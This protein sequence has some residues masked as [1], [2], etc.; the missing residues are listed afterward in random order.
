[1]T[2]WHCLSVKPEELRLDTT[3]NC[4]QSF[5]W[6]NTGDNQ[7]TSVLSG[8]I[9]TLRQTDDDIL[10]R[11]PG[12]NVGDVAELLRDYFQ[13]DVDLGELYKQWRTDANFE[14]KAG[15]FMGIR[16]LR[17]DPVE[18]LFTFICTS[19]NN[20]QRITT[21]VSKLCQH[22]GTEIGTVDEIS[23]PFY[24]FPT[25]AR[26]AQ[27]NVENE[28]RQ[29]GFGY[30][31]KYISQTA[32]YIM[33]HHDET[34]LRGLRN[35]PYEE[36][37]D[38]L[39]KLAGVGPKVADCVCLMSMDKPGAIP[40]D[41]HVW[42]IAKRDYKLSGL[43]SKTLTQKNYLAIGDRFRTIFGT[44]AGWAHSVLFTADLRQFEHRL[45]SSVEN[46]SNIVLEGKREEAPQPR[47][48]KKTA[49]VTVLDRYPR[50]KRRIL[51]GDHEKK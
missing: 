33:E 51:E 43:A 7:W 22:Y 49:G 8:R 23:K 2:T 34:W 5:R 21:M 11:T 42:Q 18:N 39:L 14:K 30:R 37:R 1:M 45:V 35:L 41:T 24:S 31:A 46:K 25:V 26:L 48:P 6:V 17:Q 29:L 4:G 13:L 20:I 40:V 3:L 10:Y 19:N 32:R 38:E 15:R 50:R 44:H 16:I 12:D 28:L 36:C 47:R 27:E 9:I